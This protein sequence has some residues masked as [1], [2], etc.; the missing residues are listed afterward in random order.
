MQTSTQSKSV[1]VKGFQIVR[2]GNLT[3]LVKDGKTVGIVSHHEKS[4]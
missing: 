2:Q 1:E 3:L 4:V